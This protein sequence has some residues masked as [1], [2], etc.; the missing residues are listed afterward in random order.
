VCVCVCVLQDLFAYGD[1]DGKGREARLQHPLGVVW[2]ETEKLLYVADSY[3]H[4]IKVVDPTTKRCTTLAGTGQS[5]LVDGPFEHAQFSE[6][7]GLCLDP[8]ERELFVADTNNHVIRVLDLD[9]RTV[10]QLRVKAPDVSVT[11]SAPAPGFK[12]LT[13]KRAQVVQCPPVTVGGG[14]GGEVRLTLHVT[15]PPST[16]WTSGATSAWQVIPEPGVLES[17]H[18]WSGV[19]QPHQDISLTLVTAEGL[20]PTSS[21]VQIELLVYFCEAS[22]VCHMQGALLAIPLV[23]SPSPPSTPSQVTLHY[24]PQLPKTG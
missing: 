9:Q 1:V 22:G 4:K 15:L 18:P 17:C 13:G 23:P 21:T 20:E 14:G 8:T 24:S 10:T 6:P 3:N 7:G 11:R 12:R 5:G 16:D 2:S 19:I